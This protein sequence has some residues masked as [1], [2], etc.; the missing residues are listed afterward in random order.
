[1]SQ[2]INYP[3]IASMVFGQPL[4]ATHQLVQSV[5]A[6]LEPRLLG[7]FTANAESVSVVVNDLKLANQVEARSNDL[8]AINGVMV[9]GKLAIISVH[10][11]LVPRAGTIDASCNELISYEK[12]RNQISMAVEHELVEHIVLD[13]HSGG[14]AAMGCDECAEFI[15]AMSQIK[16]ITAIINYAAY[17]AAFYLAAACSE[18]IA[19]PTS[20]VGSIGVII[21]TAEISKY[22]EKMG[23]TYNTFYRGAHKND[24]S[25][26]EEIT[27]QAVAEINK[28]LDSAYAMFTNSVAKHRDI[29][30]DDVI[31][32][33]ARLLDPK[34]ALSLKLIDKIMPAQDAVNQLAQQYQIHSKPKSRSIQAQAKMLDM[35]CKL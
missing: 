32:T 21:E 20:G 35:N 28:R 7:Q 29:S 3:H 13:F 24:F 26:H 23:V 2:L 5:K 6:V 22:E 25:P 12:L 15:R 33:E 1:M 11:I 8:M 16:P 19:S 30:V 27:D 17:S 34:E 14:G 18:I 10:G 4:F 31:A 9:A